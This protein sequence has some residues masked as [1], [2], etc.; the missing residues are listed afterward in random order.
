MKRK[1]Q[2]LTPEGRLEAFYKDLRLLDRLTRV[3]HKKALVAD[4]NTAW[5]HLALKCLER[6]AVGPVRT[7]LHLVAEMKRP[8]TSEALL[9]AINR[10]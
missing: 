7:D 9:S 10:H 8:S 5:D 2:A 4:D 3:V 1:Q 6:H